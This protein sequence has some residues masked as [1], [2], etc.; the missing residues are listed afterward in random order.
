MFMPH[1]PKT[2]GP[3]LPLPMPDAFTPEQPPRPRRGYP[4]AP[5]PLAIAINHHLGAVFQNVPRTDQTR[6][7][8]EQLFDAIWLKDDGAL[9]ALALE[10]AMLDPDNAASAHIRAACTFRTN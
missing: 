6:E 3:D 2:P 4:V 1:D 9:Q 8:Q 7:L 10:V 5:T